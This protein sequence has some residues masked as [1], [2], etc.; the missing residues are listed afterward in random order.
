MSYELDFFIEYFN[1]L[2]DIAVVILPL[3]GVGLAAYVPKA[4]ALKE[5]VNYLSN[6][7]K[8]NQEIFDEIKSSKSNSLAKEFNKKVDPH[9]D[10]SKK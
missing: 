8:P 3:A 4:K 6:I 10:Y 7:D 2:I 1:A 9:L 5:A